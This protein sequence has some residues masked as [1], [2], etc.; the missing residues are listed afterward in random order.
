[1]NRF[2]LLISTLE[3]LGMSEAIVLK[4][5]YS[6]SFVLTTMLIYK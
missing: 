3:I 1:M 2:E 5:N 4:F 6:D